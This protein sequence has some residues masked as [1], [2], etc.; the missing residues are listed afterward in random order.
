MD[1]IFDFVYADYLEN[2]YY[3]QTGVEQII[4]YKEKP[5]DLHKMKAAKRD[6]KGTKIRV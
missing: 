6:G 4:S 5:V 2:V 3:L 1:E